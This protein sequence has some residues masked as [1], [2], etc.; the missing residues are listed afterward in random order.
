MSEQIEGLQAE[1]RLNTQPY[2][3]AMKQAATTARSFV[4][5]LNTQLD[6]A[7][8]SMQS[9]GKT[10][11]HVGQSLTGLSRVAKGAMGQ[12]SSDV[13]GIKSVFTDLNK[14][15]QNTGQ[16]VKTISVEK[17]FKPVSEA[18]M[19]SLRT[20]QAALAATATQ[21]EEMKNT[22]QKA[23]T[24]IRRTVKA[25]QETYQALSQGIEA[26]TAS[27]KGSLDGWQT[28]QAAV[29]AQV[30][31]ENT[32]IRR[33]FGTTI[34]KIQATQTA[35]KSVADEVTVSLSQVN[36]KASELKTQDTKNGLTKSLEEVPKA[37][38]QAKAS[39][40]TVMERLRLLDQSLDAMR[41]VKTARDDLSASK[42]NN[43]IANTPAAPAQNIPVS[44]PGASEAAG[45][46]NALAEAAVDATEGM[47]AAASAA[48]EA[49]GATQGAAQNTNKMGQAFTRVKR[50]AQTAWGGLKEAAQSYGKALELNRQKMAQLEKQ[51][52]K[53][54]RGVMDVFKGIV[55]A[56]SFYKVVNAIQGAVGAM[57]DMAAATETTQASLGI[58]LKDMGQAKELTAYLQDFAAA[59]TF[60]FETASTATRQLLAYGFQLENVGYLMNTI[61]DAAAAMGEP[62]AFGAIAKALGQITTK[63][64]VATQ[65]IIQLTEA[66]IPAY[67]IL[68][69]ELGLTQKQLGN[70]GKEGITANKAVEAILLGME[71]RF[72]GS[73]DAMAKTVPG[74]WSNIKEAISFLGSQAMEGF[75]G[76]VKNVLAK[77]SE[78]INTWVQV[79]RTSGIGGLFEYIV[80]PAWQDQIRQL[81]ANVSG[82]IQ[83]FWGWSQ[84]LAPLNNV[85]MSQLINVLNLALPSIQ[86]TLQ[87]LSYL[88]NILNQNEFAVRAL[89]SALTGL[90][91]FKTVNKVAA[92]ALS[93][94]SG[95]G[96]IT[97]LIPGFIATAKSVG[98]LSASVGVLKGIVTGGVSVAGTLATIAGVGIALV[99]M[100]KA[101]D[102]AS[103]SLGSAMGNNRH[104]Y[105]QPELKRTNV[106]A[107]NFNKTLGETVGKTEAIG[108]NFDKAAEKAKKARSAI[109]SFDEIFAL[110]D[111]D[112]GASDEAEDVPGVGD[113]GDIEMPDVGGG[114]DI[115]DLIPD[116]SELEEAIAGFQAN[117]EWAVKNHFNPST[118]WSR[119]FEATRKGWRQGWEQLEGVSLASLRALG[120]T[121]AESVAALGKTIYYALTGQWD[122]IGKVW[123]KAGS[124]IAQEWNRAWNKILGTSSSAMDILEHSTK[125]DMSAV[126]RT[127]KEALKILP[128]TT[129]ETVGKAAE[130]FVGLLQDLDEDSIT[131]L[132][133]TSESMGLIFRGIHADM[134]KQEAMEQFTKN[135]K[136]MVNTGGN[137]MDTLAQDFEKAMKI[138]SS[139]CITET[140][141][142]QKIAELVFGSMKDNVGKSTDSMAKDVLD[143]V[144]S[145]GNG[146]V[147]LLKTLGGDWYTI[148]KGIEND[149]DLTSDETRAKVVANIDQMKKDGTWNITELERVTRERLISMAQQADERT[150]ELAKSVDTGTLDASKFAGINARLITEN[151]DAALSLLPDQS[152]TT[153]AAAK[154]AMIDQLVKAGALTSKQATEIRRGVTNNLNPVVKDTK[155]TF[156]SDLPSIIEGQKNRLKQAGTSAGDNVGRSY[157]EA[158]LSQMQEAF[159]K[160]NAARADLNSKMA[161][162]FGGTNV[163]PL[164]EIP[165]IPGYAKGG[166][167]KRQ[168]LAMVGEGNRQEA[169]LPLEDPRAMETI[170]NVIA[171]KVSSAMAGGI[172]MM[173]QMN[174]TTPGTPEPLRPLYVGTLIAD[175]RGLRELNRKLEVINVQEKERRGL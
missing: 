123:K 20:Y 38:E 76:S 103:A 21:T 98:I 92:G 119:F 157:K 57:W 19:E 110:P 6:K 104:N 46:M 30:L 112:S 69:E 59:S 36:K 121:I 155:K 72:K 48:K 114:I 138:I 52:A 107:T 80:P 156:G 158:M 70:L 127:F 145:M 90:L 51:A 79:V 11:D 1:L 105:L 101:F 168:H 13:S 167:I 170:G 136:S 88:V 25:T 23:H 147:E 102:K 35:L 31:Q 150:K 126:T 109:A 84:A 49:S 153:L 8:I 40:D 93:A 111:E 115:G 95:F 4:N 12:I 24:A 33:T 171:S 14:E 100:N 140:Q 141:K 175:D 2:T 50:D 134:T 55:L 99:G 118:T 74:Y 45:S 97:K 86:A 163:R 17:T 87:I 152:A 28:A 53:T 106:T 41:S 160:I 113:I 58:L 15:I 43:V 82:V 85:F 96:G 60:T 108:N 71:K 94:L 89:A 67:Q 133:G 39:T 174:N 44:T 22:T 120:Y 172:Q 9:L 54:S 151:I 63:G 27:I 162:A 131:V 81:I 62:E 16:K 65:E 142:T 165:R 144:E 122:E 68:R 7:N 75:Y 161:D 32:A 139:T 77:T 164:P 137:D 149:S 124:T 29:K 143:D 83:A 125:Q 154:D 159:D 166:L 34:E 26:S 117:Y 47:H 173:S 18:T 37:A 148:F 116:L 130:K 73:M 129:E 66:G 135:I 56:Q 10:S 5:T 3:Q 132:K 42:L 128:K 91:V 61:G 78:T 169:V 64:K 146:S